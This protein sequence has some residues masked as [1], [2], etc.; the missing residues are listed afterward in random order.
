MA[1]IHRRRQMTTLYKPVLIE[2]AEPAEALPEGT[3][4]TDGKRAAVEQRHTSHRAT[5]RVSWR[6]TDD[7]WDPYFISEKV[8]G[9]T[10]LVP[11]PAEQATRAVVGACGSR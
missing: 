8:D 2:S 5:P 9:S 10:A 6:V 4:A 1:H 11:L 7:P 3:I